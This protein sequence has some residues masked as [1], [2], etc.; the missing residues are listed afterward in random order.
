VSWELS[1]D[2]DRR[3]VLPHIPVLLSGSPGREAHDFF[4]FDSR[5]P[6]SREIAATTSL[7]LKTPELAVTL[8]VVG[9]PEVKVVSPDKRA[10]RT[11]Q[12]WPKTTSP[13]TRTNQELRVLRGIKCFEQT[14][15]HEGITDAN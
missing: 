15:F 14:Q 5:F 6:L 13:V 8:R 11:S 3:V 2:T 9:K 1:K 7:A 12:N 4:T 10:N